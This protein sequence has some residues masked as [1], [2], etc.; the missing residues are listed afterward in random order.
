VAWGRGRSGLLVGT[1][2]LEGLGVLL[3]ETR[4]LHGSLIVNRQRLEKEIIITDSSRN[5]YIH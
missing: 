3:E 1:E 4:G 2:K 5:I